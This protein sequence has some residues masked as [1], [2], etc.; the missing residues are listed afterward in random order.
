VRARWIRETHDLTTLGHCL[1]VK[2][3]R[4]GKLRHCDAP[5]FLIGSFWKADA[6]THSSEVVV[7][8]KNPE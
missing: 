4:L 7:K 5:R 6:S 3:R 8:Q 2:G 1:N